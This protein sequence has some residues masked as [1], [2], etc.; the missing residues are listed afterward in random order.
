MN[1]HLESACPLAHAVGLLGDRWTLVIAREALRGAERYDE[2]RTALGISD[3]TLSRRLKEM[4]DLGLLESAGG[5][6]PVYRLTPAGR[7]LARV[8]AVL[9]DWNQRWFPVEATAVPPELVVDAASKLGLA[10][11]GPARRRRSGSGG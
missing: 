5:T 8:L 6:R 7:D 4:C 11:A 9:G 10:I 1:P 2:F 3:N